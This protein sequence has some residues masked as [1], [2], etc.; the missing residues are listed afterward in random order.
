M[1]RERS[2]WYVA[3]ILPSVLFALYALWNQDFVAALVAYLAL[4]V[5]AVLYLNYSGRYSEHFRSILAKY[6]EK[7]GALREPPGE[8]I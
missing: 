1:S 4:L 7:V 2:L 8:Q 3:Y 6:E 5:V